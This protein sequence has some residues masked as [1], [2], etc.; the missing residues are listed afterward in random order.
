MKRTQRTTGFGSPAESYA[1]NDIDW[2]SLLLPK[3]HAMYVFTV[4]GSMNEEYKICDKDLAI[5]DC[6]LVP[7][8]G[9]LII[10]TV[11][12]EFVIGKYTG[13]ETDLVGVV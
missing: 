5:I 13:P 12:G 8:I 11:D 1:E 7:K 6:S 3:P 2:T 10:Y 9:D 4:R